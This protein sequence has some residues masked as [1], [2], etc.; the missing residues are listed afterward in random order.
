MQ[1]EPRHITLQVRAGPVSCSGF[2]TGWLLATS[3]RRVR[4]A[5]A[6]RSALRTLSKALTHGFTQSCAA[7]F[8]M[9]P[10][11][12]ARLL[13]VSHQRVMRGAASLQTMWTRTVR[14]VTHAVGEEPRHRG[15]PLG[16]RRVLLL[17][18]RAQLDLHLMKSKGFPVQTRISR[19]TL[20]GIRMGSMGK[21]R[22]AL[23]TQVQRRLYEKKLCTSGSRNRLSPAPRP[24]A[25]ARARTAARCACF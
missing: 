3:P 16:D 20:T 6:P 7:H 22:L 11:P 17:S 10:P 25:F 9:A 12:S 19:G 13:F 8:V 4:R 23:R 18:R 24:P 15:P 5:G 2:L 14:V 21:V 1:L